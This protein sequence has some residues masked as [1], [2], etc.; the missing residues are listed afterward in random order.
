[1]SDRVPSGSFLTILTGRRSSDSSIGLDVLP[2]DWRYVGIHPDNPTYWDLTRQPN[3]EE[4]MEYICRR[5]G[6]RR[7]PPPHDWAGE[8]D[9]FPGESEPQPGGLGGCGDLHDWVPVVPSPGAQD[10]HPAAGLID[11]AAGY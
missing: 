10:H 4:T 9:R 5:C 6:D 11:P 7:L 3:K 2:E 8:C 1:M